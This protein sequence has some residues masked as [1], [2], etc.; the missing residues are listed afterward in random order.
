[1]KD[2]TCVIEVGTH[3]KPYWRDKTSGMIVCT[4]HKEQFETSGYGPF[5]WGIYLTAEEF[6]QHIET[7]K[8]L[9]MDT[10]VL[11]A[12]TFS[13]YLTKEQIISLLREGVDELERQAT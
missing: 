7:A 3:P 1:M 13:P 10:L 6:Q 4:R 2:T 12:Q 11:L 9:V 8:P 5:D